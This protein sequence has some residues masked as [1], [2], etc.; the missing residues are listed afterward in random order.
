MSTKD[1]PW[2]MP[3]PECGRRYFN[4]G[5]AASH[6]AAKAGI[7]PTMQ[8]TPKIKRALP[9]LLEQRLTREAKGD[10]AA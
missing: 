5:K 1:T 4:L 3:I 6:R 2:T 7:I 9:R 10:D 8:V